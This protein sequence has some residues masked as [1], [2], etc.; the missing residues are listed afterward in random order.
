MQQPRGGK[1]VSAGA[2]AGVQDQGAAQRFGLGRDPPAGKL[3]KARAIHAELNWSER[4][5]EGCRGAGNAARWVQNK[6]PLGTR[7]DNADGGVGAEE[8]GEEDSGERLQNPTKLNEGNHLCGPAGGRG[9]GVIAWLHPRSL[10]RRGRR[11]SAAGRLGVGRHG[12]SSS[13]PASHGKRP[14]MQRVN[15]ICHRSGSGK[16]SSRTEG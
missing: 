1:S 15:R 4:Q 12:A 11:G 16:G 2:I 13:P 6:L 14:Q 7:E 5:M 3:G 8:G 10:G 9:A